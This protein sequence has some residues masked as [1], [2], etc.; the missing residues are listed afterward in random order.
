M[1]LLNDHEKH[2]FIT[3][4]QNYNMQVYRNV[5]LY[6]WVIEGVILKNIVTKL[7]LLVEPSNF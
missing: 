2:F 5:S 6:L 7:I 1:I 3:S 4:M